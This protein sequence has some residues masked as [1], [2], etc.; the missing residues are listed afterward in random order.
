MNNIVDRKT[1]VGVTFVHKNRFYYYDTN[2]NSLV[3]VS[4]ETY[5]LEFR[6]TAL[7]LYTNCLKKG[8]LEQ[9]RWKK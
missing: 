1:P 7:T 8:T 6:M 3:E 5:N 9:W 4:A 2:R